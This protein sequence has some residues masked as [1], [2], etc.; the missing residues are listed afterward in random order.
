VTKELLQDLRPADQ[1]QITGGQTIANDSPAF[2][3]LYDNVISRGRIEAINDGVVVF[4]DQRGP[5]PIT[6]VVNLDDDTS[7]IRVGE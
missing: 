4:S 2:R 1:Q 6:L 5:V 7:S 3:P